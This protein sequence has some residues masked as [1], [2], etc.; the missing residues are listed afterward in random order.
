[1]LASI[2]IRYARLLDLL[3]SK[4]STTARC[5]RDIDWPALLTASQR[6]GTPM[7][8]RAPLDKRAAS[9]KKQGSQPRS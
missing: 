1:M 4:P 6:P 5:A 7:D 3:P 9:S 8:R 2:P